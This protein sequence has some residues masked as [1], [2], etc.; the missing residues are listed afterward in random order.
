MPA[1][2]AS[3]PPLPAMPAPEAPQAAFPSQIPQAPAVESQRA[4]GMET[5]EQRRARVFAEFQQMRR[6]A[7]EE[8]RKHWEGMGV[9]SPI[10]PYGYPGYVPAPGYGQGP[11]AP[12]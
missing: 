10:P 9:P 12:R 7:Q 8:M 11:Y 5:I 2:P 4:P 6:A 1:A 3:V